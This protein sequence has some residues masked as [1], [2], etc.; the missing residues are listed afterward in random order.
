[1]KEFVQEV[2]RILSDKL[3]EVLDIV[4]IEEV[5]FAAVRGG[6]DDY[7]TCALPKLEDM[8]EHLLGQPTALEDVFEIEQMAF[9]QADGGNL[10]VATDIAVHVQ[11]KETK[12]F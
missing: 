9:E 8:V 6:I 10:D 3:E 11:E 2:V 12:I 7:I 4:V 5:M 1:V